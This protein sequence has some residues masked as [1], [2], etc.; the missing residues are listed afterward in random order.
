[1]RAED[2]A[3][4]LTKKTAKP[5]AYDVAI[6]D[7]DKKQHRFY[8]IEIVGVRD[9]AVEA[10]VAFK[11]SVIGGEKIAEPRHCGETTI[12]IREGKI[13]QRL[14]VAVKISASIEAV[15]GIAFPMG[16]QERGGRLLGS[17]AICTLYQY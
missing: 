15:R 8:S 11:H 3:N 9:S 12:P 16:R 2:V 6:V 4:Y 5:I 10:M 7:N 17:L 1:M 14:P 13:G